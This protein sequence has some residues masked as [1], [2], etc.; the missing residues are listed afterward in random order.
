MRRREFIAGLAGATAWPVA[1]RAQQPAVPVVGYLD[2]G[3]P[4]M[5]KS[6]VAVFRKGLSETGHV[7]GRNLAIEY[8]FADNQIDRLPE[9]A[10][11]L[12]RRG[13]AVIVARPGPAALAA[14]G[15][16]STI[17]IVFE[18]GADPVK[19]GLVA[20]LNRP[21]GN[22]TGAASLNVELGPKRLALLRQV[23]PSATIIAML[24]D[25]ADPN[26]EDGSR[27]MQ[28]AAHALGVQLHILRTNTEHDITMAFATLT[29]LRAGALAI[30]GGAFLLSRIELLTALTLRHSVPSIAQ[31]RDFAVAGGLMSYG[32]NL[33]ESYRLAGVYAGRI[34]KGEKPGD[35]P[36][37]QSTKIELVINV[38]TAKALGLT[39][40]ET[41]LA[42]ADE[43]IQ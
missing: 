32:G 12:V 15:A 26:F 4:G 27:E 8:R 17:P 42:T 7:E 43:V 11:D 25:P 29:K 35:L 3:P 14:K 22:I 33:A 21:G 6:L 20:N 39:I 10:A 28:A 1:A 38:M 34:L 41:L 24:R 5:R 13:V 9:L 18:T 40:P 31:D 2:L 19:V 30:G 23:V 36:V 16:T 37:Q